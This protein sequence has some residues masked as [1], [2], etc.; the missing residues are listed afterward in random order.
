MNVKAELQRK[1]PRMPGMAPQP[2]CSRGDWWTWLLASI[3]SFRAL[4]AQPRLGHDGMPLCLCFQIKQARGTSSH[5]T[6]SHSYRL[7]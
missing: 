6:F 7:F 3:L 4:R 5:T 2:I 1:D